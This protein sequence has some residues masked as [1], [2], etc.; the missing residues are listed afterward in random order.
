[1]TEKEKETIV[2][3]LEMGIALSRIYLSRIEY[4]YEDAQEEND[5]EKEDEYLLKIIE[6]RKTIKTLT[7]LKDQYK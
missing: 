2:D 1:M 4:L 6:C 7:K 5:D 3:A